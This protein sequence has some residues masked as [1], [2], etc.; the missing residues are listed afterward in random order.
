MFAATKC[1][2]G[3]AST[4]VVTDPYFNLVSAL[5]HADGTNGAQ[6]NTFIDSSPNNFTVTRLGNTAQGSFSP[7]GNSWS[8]YFNGTT[9]YMTFPNASGFAFGTGAFTIEFWFNGR[10]GQSDRFILSGRSAI[11]TLHITTGGAS[12]TTIGALRYVGSTTITSGATL[13]CDGTWH[14]C[15]IVRGASS[16]VTLYVDGVARGT[17]TDTTNYTTTSGTWFVA[18][19]NVAP[20]ANL[21]SAFISNMRIVSGTAVYTGTFTPP[22]APLTAI[23]GTAFLSFQSNRFIDNSSLNATLTRVGTPVIPRL[24]PFSSTAYSTTNIGGSAYFD[25]TGDYLTVPDNDAFEVSGDFT[26]EAWFYCTAIPSTFGDI[27]TKGATGIYQPYYIFINSSGNLLFYSSSN[28]TSWNVANGVSFGSVSVNTWYHV[29][30]SRVGTAMRLFLNGVLANT[31]TNGSALF[32]NTR[33]VAVGARSDGTETFTG[34]IT[35]ARII[36]GEGIYTATFTPPTTPLTSVPSTAL[37]INCTAA[38]IF[39]NAMANDF[40]TVSTAQITTAQKVFGTGSMAFNGSTAYIVSRFTPPLNTQYTIE[41]WFYMNALAE[42]VLVFFGTFGS[43]SNR[44]QI[45]VRS[46]GRIDLYEDLT[47]TGLYSAMSATGTIT[48]NTWYY[49]A[50]TY[51]GSTVRLFINGTLVASAAYTGATRYSATNCFL[52]YGRATSTNRYLNG[53]IDE[54]RVTRGLARYTSNFTTPTSPFPDQ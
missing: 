37:L 45:T 39:D 51:D 44:L 31:I 6:N 23:A 40:E 29:A 52:G 17:G 49:C 21:V 32:N 38:A 15:A 25:G 47:G 19:N 28:G 11:G 20:P 18:S 27:I 2:Y 4:P 33:A 7:Y 36:N 26:V 43:D 10:A 13:I 8:V 48:T 41:F 14:H 9:D 12:G 46:D 54:F 50:G 42:R 3:A 1:G 5:V 34:Y 22:T 24:G 16:N 30:V 53:Y 35:D